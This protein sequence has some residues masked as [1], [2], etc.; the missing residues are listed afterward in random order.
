MISGDD[1]QRYVLF[2]PTKLSFRL[3]TLDCRTHQLYPQGST[4]IED[5]FRRFV[6]AFAPTITSSQLGVAVG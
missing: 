3:S 1:S 4:D 2:V 6:V 5:I